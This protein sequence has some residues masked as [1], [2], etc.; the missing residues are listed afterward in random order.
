MQDILYN[1]KRRNNTNFGRILHS[2][3]LTIDF[4][5]LLW[6]NNIGVLYCTIITFFMIREHQGMT[7]MTERE[8][9]KMRRSDL[10]ELMLAQSR[11]IER[12]NAQLESVSEKLTD[13]YLE[14]DNSGSIAEAA[15]Q[16]NHVFAAAQAA[17]DQYTLNVQKQ[18]QRQK[19]LCLQMERETRDKCD[20][21]IADAQAQS[22]A[23]WE[24][25]SKKINDLMEQSNDLRELLRFSQSKGG[26]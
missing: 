6:Y 10:V 8:L 17:C 3:T 19:Q 13:K 4:N 25:V 23:Y 9:K 16:L 14:I 18:T 7:L 2:F 1:I 22:D 20:K 12:L 5:L 26:I 21:M 11:E 15:L 24:Q